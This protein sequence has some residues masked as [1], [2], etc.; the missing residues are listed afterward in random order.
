MGLAAAGSI[1]L[2]LPAFSL[3]EPHISIMHKASERKRISAELQK[4]LSELGRSKPY[5]EAS[6]SFN[7]IV[8]LLIKSE[9][10][11]RAGLKRA[12]EGL[13]KA[14]KMIPLD[15]DLFNDAVEIQASLDMSMQDAI[16]LACVL[17]HLAET[18][19]ANSCFINRNT[20]DFDDPNVLEMLEV[21]GCRF[22]GRFDHALAYIEAQSRRGSP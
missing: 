16:V 19:P 15:S 8:D 9:D 13:L 14:A 21:F 4:Q 10:S 18:R 20:R 17:H 11:E 1:R 22:F 5:R 12:T 3:V 7:A 6:G 2:F